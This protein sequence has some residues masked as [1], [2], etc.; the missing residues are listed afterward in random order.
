MN[1]KISFQIETIDGH[2]LAVDLFL[3]EIPGTEKLSTLVYCHGFKGFKDWG[4]VPHLNQFLV[5]E[6]LAL[7]TFNH[8]HNG[9][10][11][12]DFDDLESFADNSVGQELRDLESL[13]LWIVNEGKELY[14]FDPENINW[15]GHSRG[16]GNVILFT[17]LFPE[18]VKKAITWAA[19]DTFTHILRG[20]DKEQWKKEGRVYIENARTKQQ[21]PLNYFIYEEYIQ[22]E[23]KYSILDAANSLTKPLLIVHGT[24]DQSVPFSSAENIYNAC[25]HSILYKVEGGD[26]TFGVAH[27]IQGLQDVNKDFWLMLDNTLEFIED[28]EI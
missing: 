3:P 25:A 5:T 18:Y 20:L 23:K 19:I 26:H 13:A 17:K 28:T 14:N 11:T 8:S 1:R 16:G 2:Q 22:N 6:N 27:P 15:L 9:V 21:M 12:R 7:I 24:A 4:F 10:I